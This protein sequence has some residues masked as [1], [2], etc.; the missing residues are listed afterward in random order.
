M[1]EDADRDE[2][3]SSESIHS[4]GTCSTQRA[5]RRTKRRRTQSRTRA[6]VLKPKEPDTYNGTPHIETFPKFM[7]ESMEYLDDY[8]VPARQQAQKIAR[9]LKGDAYKFYPNSVAQQ[10]RRW[11]LERLF[12]GLFDYCF[13]VDFRLQMRERLKRST[14]GKRSVRAYVHELESLF[15]VVG[16]VSERDRVDRLWYG[17][18]PYLQKQL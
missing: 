3:T 18:S 2:L 14:Q 16:G 6:P 15:M 8:A 12:E 17:L 4:T 11:S 10:P 5:R 1:D 7:A 13:P 9:F